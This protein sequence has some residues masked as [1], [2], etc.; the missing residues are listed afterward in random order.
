VI[1]RDKEKHIPDDFA[2]AVNYAVSYLY[3]VYSKSYPKITM[4]PSKIKEL[5]AELLAELDGDQI[6]LNSEYAE[7]VL[8]ATSGSK[9]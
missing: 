5:T 6:D 8:A 4:S 7:E 9:N 3:G 2:D 1:G